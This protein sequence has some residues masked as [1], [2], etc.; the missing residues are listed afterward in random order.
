VVVLQH[1]RVVEDGPPG[2]LR[3]AG[4]LYEQLWKAQAKGQETA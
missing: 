1:G 2:R 3:H 4:G